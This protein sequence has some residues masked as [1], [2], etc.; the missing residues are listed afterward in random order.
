MV[1]VTIVAPRGTYPQFET[2]LR[3]RYSLNEAIVAECYEDREEAIL[4][5]IGAAAAHYLGGD[6]EAKAT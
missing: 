5:A 1:R 6:A 3:E 4:S 2:A